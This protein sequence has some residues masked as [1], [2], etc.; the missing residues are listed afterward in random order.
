MKY[1]DIEEFLEKYPHMGMDVRV[2]SRVIHGYYLVYPPEP[3]DVMMGYNRY[4]LHRGGEGIIDRV[5]ARPVTEDNGGCFLT[6]E[7]VPL[8]GDSL[9]LD[10]LSASY[11][12][13][14]FN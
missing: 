14:V 12:M 4:D 9:E 8:N 13:P 11:V 5:V 2:G 3:G 1:Q 6:K 10:G 7:L